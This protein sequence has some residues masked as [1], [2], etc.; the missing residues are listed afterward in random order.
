MVSKRGK[1]VWKVHVYGGGSQ[2]LVVIQTWS[3]KKCPLSKDLEEVSE[4]GDFWRSSIPG[5][6]TLQGQMP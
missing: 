5:P 3:L 2:R 6:R 4:K 1:R